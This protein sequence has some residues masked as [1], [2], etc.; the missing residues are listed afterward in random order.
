M[1]S[2]VVQNFGGNPQ[3][4]INSAMWFPFPFDVYDVRQV[5]IGSWD[6]VDDPND[7]SP[8]PITGGVIT[9]PTLGLPDVTF[10][11]NKH[12]KAA[13]RGNYLNL[14][15]Y[16]TYTLGFPGVG[17]VN[18]DNTKLQGETG[19]T[20][21]RY[22]DAFSGQLFIKVIADSSGQIL[23]YLNGQIGI[24]ISLRG[25]NNANSLVSGAA[26]TVTGIIGAVASGGMAAIAGA[27]EAGIATALEAVGGTPTS[28]SMG[29]G[30]AGIT[31]ER[32]WFDTICM[33]VA[34]ADNTH[35]GRPLCQVAT[36]SSL[37]GY[38]RVSE[39]DVAIPGP[40]PEAMEVKRMLEA[41]FF[42]E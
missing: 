32:I 19:I 4:L 1:V 3:Q 41:G 36:I 34:D 38:I 5:T 35:D 40:L 30:F 27:A 11:I 7:P 12:P 29:C 8:T 17:V 21:K 13:T 42:Y 39:G 9:D 2:K 16:T 33:D 23:A 15:P 22:M 6:A 18:L 28:S 14:A 24:P 10:T 25:S 37:S 31:D 20:I 26:A